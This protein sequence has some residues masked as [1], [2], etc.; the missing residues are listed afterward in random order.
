MDI[1]LLF[2]GDNVIPG[3]LETRLF[4]VLQV[5]LNTLKRARWKEAPALVMN[6]YLL[7]VFFFILLRFPIPDFENEETRFG[8]CLNI[9]YPTKPTLK[10]RTI[11][12]FHIPSMK[13]SMSV[14][15]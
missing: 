5:V 6:S 8:I 15:D 3:F 14:Q 4:S 12:I 13:D 10:I 9:L 7:V 11:Y 1:A 2:L